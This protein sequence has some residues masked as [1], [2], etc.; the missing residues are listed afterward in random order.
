MTISN[1]V[2]LITEQQNNYY[3]PVAVEELKRCALLNL[4]SHKFQANSTAKS[5]LLR[6][7]QLR[8]HICCT[9]LSS[10]SRVLY[11]WCVKDLCET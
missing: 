7:F 1:R 10:Q 9:L 2:N 4:V 8:C 3:H 6:L 11:N 5:Y